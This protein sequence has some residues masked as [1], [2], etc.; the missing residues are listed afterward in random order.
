MSSGLI[1][2]VNAPSLNPVSTKSAKNAYRNVNDN[3]GPSLT[4]IKEM[5]SS[6]LTSSINILNTPKKPK[7]QFRSPKLCRHQNIYAT[8]FYHQISILLIRTFIILWRDRSLSAIRFAIS[9]VTA[10]LIG[11]LYYGIGNDAGNALNNFRYC[12]YSIMFIMFTAFSS[13]L[14]KCKRQ[15]LVNSSN[16]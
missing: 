1:T 10:F 8:P 2:P 14:V 6:F 4:S 9:F 13:I 16:T 7:F 5:P 15:T 11:W 12:F 3:P